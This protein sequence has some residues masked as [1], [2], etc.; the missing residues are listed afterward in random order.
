MSYHGIL[1][2]KIIAHE[3]GDA[4]IPFVRAAYRSQLEAE[5][6][7]ERLRDAGDTRDLRLCRIDLSELSKPTIYDGESTVIMEFDPAMLPK[8]DA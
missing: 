3:N 5:A 1:E 6:E 8:D 2:Y 7:L 4:R